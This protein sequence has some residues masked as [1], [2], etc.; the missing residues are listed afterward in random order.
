MKWVNSD[1][2]LSLLG[3]TWRQNMLDSNLLCSQHYCP[4]EVAEPPKQ[5]VGLVMVASRTSWG[6]NLGKQLGPSVS[7]RLTRDRIPAWSLNWKTDLGWANQYLWNGSTLV[8]RIKMGKRD[9]QYLLALPENWAALVVKQTSSRKV[10]GG[11]ARTLIVKKSFTQQRTWVK[12]PLHTL[13]SKGTKYKLSYRSWWKKNQINTLFF[14]KTAF[15][16]MIS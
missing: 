2:C 16:N 11:M 15:E 4:P 9:L 7:G 8:V 5:A 14:T 12:T 10:Q 3:V 6:S 1:L 13:K